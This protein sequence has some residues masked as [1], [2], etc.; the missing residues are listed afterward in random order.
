MGACLVPIC[1][2]AGVS[3]TERETGGGLIHFVGNPVQ[4]W[5]M[6]HGNISGRECGHCI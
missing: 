6:S 5:H 1:L 4:P 2:C 3:M